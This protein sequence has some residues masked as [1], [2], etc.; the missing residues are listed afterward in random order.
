MAGCLGTGTTPSYGGTDDEQG[1]ETER[2]PVDVD[3]ES[4]TAEEMTAATALAD[5]GPAEGV[6]PLDAITFIDH[7][8]VLEDNY[9]GSTVQGTLENEGDDRLSLVEIRVRVYDDAD[10]MLGVYFSHVNDLDSGQTW[11]FSVIVL[12]SPADIAA[13]DIAALG[14]PT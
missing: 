7:E 3:G 6:S 8:F 2:V 14:T 11:A 1:A 4:R 9:L 12:Q 10:D 5:D 13:Y